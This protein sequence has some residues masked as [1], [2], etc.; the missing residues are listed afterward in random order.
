MTES[1][2]EEMREEEALE[3]GDF[4]DQSTLSYP[5]SASGPS[6]SL[7][8]DAVSEGDEAYVPPTD[9]V[10]TNTEVIGG[11]QHSSLD[12]IEV[13]RSSDG[14][15]G[16]EGIADAVRRELREDAATTDLRLDVEVFQGVVT[17][18]GRV[19]LLEDAENAEAVASMV[20]GVVEVVDEME[21]VEGGYVR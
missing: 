1:V 5:E 16:D 4:T 3:P 10:G 13:E 2:E 15:L 19:P 14:T 12:S 11:L 8:Y 9:P 6:T 18:R 7:D 17:L 20:P 21:I